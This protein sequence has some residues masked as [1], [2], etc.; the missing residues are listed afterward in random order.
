MRDERFPLLW[1]LCTF[2]MVLYNNL[3]NI[4]YIIMLGNL[5]CKSITHSTKMYPYN[6]SMLV[7][8]V[9]MIF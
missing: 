7:Y 8:K 9:E 2:I 1:E 4:V 3:A 6:N 5:S